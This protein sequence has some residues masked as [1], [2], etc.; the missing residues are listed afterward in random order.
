MYIYIP[1]YSNLSFMATQLAVTGI[2][3]QHSL[4]TG[5]SFNKKNPIQRLRAGPARSILNVT[6]VD[7]GL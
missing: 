4:S 7:A 5:A 6:S 1:L 3:A 2:T